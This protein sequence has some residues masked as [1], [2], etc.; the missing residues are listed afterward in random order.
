MF[1]L[2][3]ENVRYTADRQLVLIG[4]HTVR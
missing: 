3:R 1:D 2:A 4:E